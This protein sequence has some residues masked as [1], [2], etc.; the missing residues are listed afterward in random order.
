MSTASQGRRR[1]SDGSENGR[2]DIGTYVACYVVDCGKRDS[3][4]IEYSMKGTQ[5]TSRMLKSGLTSLVIILQDSKAWQPFLESIERVLPSGD[6]EAHILIAATGGV[7]EAFASEGV[8]LKA[9]IGFERKVLSFF[10]GR[11]VFQRLSGFEEAI[12][13]WTATIEAVRARGTSIPEQSLA[14]ECCA[15][16]LSGGGATSQLAVAEHKH[17]YVEGYSRNCCIKSP[18]GLGGLTSRIE[19]NDDEIEQGLYIFCKELEGHINGLGQ[20]LQHARGHDDGAFHGLRGIFMLIEWPSAFITSTG[21]DGLGIPYWQCKL[22]L[23]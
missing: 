13:E 19:K 10:D 11:A 2:S 4:I 14:P 16:M 17:G 6:N 12:Y 3:R 7:R 8:D 21:C 22:Q 18:N 9:L 23:N 15:G 1:A 20:K 5:L